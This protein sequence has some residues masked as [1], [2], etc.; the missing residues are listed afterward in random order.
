MNSSNASTR[1]WKRWCRGVLVTF[2]VPIVAL[3][4]YIGY[5]LYDDNFHVIVSGQAY[6]SGQMDAAEFTQVIHAYGIKSI[7]NLR[8]AN[9]GT[10]WHKAEVAT[11]RKWHVVHYDFGFGSG[12]ELSVTKMTR[13]VKLMRDAPK[14]ILIHCLGGADRSGLAASLYCYAIVGEKPEEAHQQLSFWDG[15]VP[16]IRPKVTAMDDSFWRYVSNHVAQAAVD[17][18]PATTVAR[19][20]QTN[21]SP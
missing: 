10:A 1:K 19:P 4:L 12:D 11:A 3:L 13:L 16:L 7:L 5:T 9:P 8:G 18:P 6:R 15:H 2:S 14:P 21:Q 20:P 17:K